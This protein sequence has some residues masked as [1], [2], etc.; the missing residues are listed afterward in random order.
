M[1]CF[2]IAA[3]GDAGD[4]GLVFDEGC[5][6]G[7]YSNHS[8]E[9]WTM[10]PSCAPGIGAGVS[11]D[12]VI[13]IDASG[14]QFVWSTG[15]AT[16]SNGPWASSDGGQSWVAPAGGLKVQTAS[17]AADRVQPLTFYACDGGTF[18]MSTDGG[19]SYNGTMGSAIGLPPGKCGLPI[20]NFNKAGDIWLALGGSGLYHIDDFG[21]S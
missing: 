3:G 13:V 7:T 12:G 20:V 21:H 16:Q 1:N 5:G 11:T 17:I 19:L 2:E 10:F 18:Y 8:G 15:I 6:Q 4:C 14:E 9:T